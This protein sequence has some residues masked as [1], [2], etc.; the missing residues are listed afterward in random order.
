MRGL[1]WLPIHRRL[2]AP[3]R[4]G[5]DPIEVLR[6]EPDPPD[7]ILIDD[8]EIF[9]RARQALKDRPD[10]L[11]ALTLH[12]GPGTLLGGEL[13]AEFEELFDEPAHNDPAVMDG[14][15]ISLP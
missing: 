14:A 6:A 15:A 11:A 4:S 8:L 9:T 3:G 5:D 7:E 13:Q 1:P 2:R 10:L 12:R